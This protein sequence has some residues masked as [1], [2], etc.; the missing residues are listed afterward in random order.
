MNMIIAMKIGQ[1]AQNLNRNLGKRFLRNTRLKLGQSIHINNILNGTS[2]HQLQNNLNIPLLKV[3]AVE[4]HDEIAFV[5]F[6]LLFY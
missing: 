4:R 5:A 2:I 3:S 6:M 1:P